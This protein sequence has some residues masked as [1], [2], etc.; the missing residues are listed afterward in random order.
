MRKFPV[1]GEA[2][3]TLVIVIDPWAVLEVARAVVGDYELVVT[4]DGEVIGDLDAPGP[5]MPPEAPPDFAGPRRD[6][7]PS[8]FG[9]TGAWLD[10]LF[11]G[12]RHLGEETG[13]R[14]VA[15]TCD[16]RTDGGTGMM[17][18]S[19]YFTDRRV[20]STVGD[21][22]RRHAHMRYLVERVLTTTRTEGYQEA[23]RR[24]D[25]TVLVENFPRVEH[26]YTAG[27]VI[28][29]KDEAEGLPGRIIYKAPV[30]PDRT[31]WKRK[32]L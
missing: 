31:R 23:I 29:V 15:V 14:I 26:E 30:Q 6:A 22:A 10:D 16:G 3:E 28:A 1:L 20:R 18:R 21:A 7:L 25:E 24:D 12:L 13:L 2:L 5:L 19:H 17:R 9:A 32:A 4:D 27:N 11:A 8:L